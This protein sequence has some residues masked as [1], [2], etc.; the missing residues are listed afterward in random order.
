MRASVL[1]MVGSML[2]VV[3]NA[4]AAGFDP[5][6]SVL[7]RIGVNVNVFEVNNSPYLVAALRAAG[8]RVVRPNFTASIINRG[9]TWY[10]KDTDDPNTNSYRKVI[11]T[12]SSKRVLRR[13]SKFLRF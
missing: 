1:L 12:N 6:A 13:A 4:P 3:G 10:F 11:L 5:D 7:G 9:L 2:L 8:V